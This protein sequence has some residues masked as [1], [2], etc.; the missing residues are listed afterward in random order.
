MV[1][2]LKQSLEQ[3]VAPVCPGC[4]VEM[5]WSRSALVEAS[6]I[7]ITHIF[8]CAN[9]NRMAKTTSE[10]KSS[11]IVPPDK[12]FAPRHVAGPAGQPVYSLRTRYLNHSAPPSRR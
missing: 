3:L 11:T 4:N 6:P 2:K 7:T 9:C 12:L 5:T 10:L 8:Q 1:H